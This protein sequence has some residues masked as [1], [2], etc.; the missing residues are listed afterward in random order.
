M[1]QCAKFC[2]NSQYLARAEKMLDWLASIQ[3]EDGGF[4]GGKIDATPLV[5]VTFNTGQILIGLA[6]G[7]ET[8]QKYQKETIKAANWLAGSL[9]DDG[10]W[11]RYPTPFAAQGEKAYETHVSWGLFE[12]ARIFPER[13]FGETGMR[14]VRWALTKQLDNGWFQSCCLTQ[15]DQPLTHTLGYVLRGLVEAYH[16]SGD[17]QVLD[18][19]VLT[20]RGLQTAL[21]GEGYIPGRLRSDW[22]G[23]V[24]WACLTGTVQIAHCW[25]L[26]YKA[27]SE[28]SFLDSG[29]LA[30]SYVRRTVEVQGDENIRGA[31]KGSFP[32]N[33]GYGSYE[34]LNWA[35]KFCID[36]NL[37]ELEILAGES[38]IE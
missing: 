14:Q 22:S 24:P 29:L 17:Q 30:N 37:C 3:F 15:P 7:V 35:A 36:S 5:P 20:A 8:F 25:L 38:A 2:N 9:D 34:Y 10:C 23:T 28:T 4:Q 31:V 13:E 18:A 33:G 11:R 32:V 6:S 27:T 19:A 16:W 26:L 1:I 21:G 12:A